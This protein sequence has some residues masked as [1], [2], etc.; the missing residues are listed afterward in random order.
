MK[1]G[2]VLVAGLSVAILSIAT[3]SAGPQTSSSYFNERHVGDPDLTRYGPAK[4]R[5]FNECYEALWK[6][7]VGVSYI[8]AVCNSMRYKS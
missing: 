7:G 1:A 6:Q 3:A 2:V 8:S 5:T 4:A